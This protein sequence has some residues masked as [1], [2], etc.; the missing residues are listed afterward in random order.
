[1]WNLHRFRRIEAESST[2]GAADL[3]EAHSTVLL[4]RLGRYQA[5]TQRGYYRALQELR[6]L[7]TN[8]ALRNL[9][10][11]EETRQEVPAVADINELTKQTRSEVTAEALEHALKMVEYETGV[12]RLQAF[13]KHTANR[14]VSAPPPPES[15]PSK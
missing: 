10:L 6:A 5:R 13:Q 3:T 8:R 14:T 7:Q 9:K 2:G 12:L 4:D 11:D 1:A 15:T